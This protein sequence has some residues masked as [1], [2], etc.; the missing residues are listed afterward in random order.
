[1]INNELLLKGKAREKLRE[2]GLSLAHWEGKVLEQVCDVFALGV[3]SERMTIPDPHSVLGLSRGADR[4][5]VKRAYRQKAL[6]THP[7]MWV[8]TMMTCLFSSPFP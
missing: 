4:A 1:M 2:H 6:Q 7:D 3:S 5:A 8:L